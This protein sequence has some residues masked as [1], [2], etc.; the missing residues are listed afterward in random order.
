MAAGG[1]MV[2]DWFI[3][4]IQKH[5]AQLIGD[6]ELSQRSPRLHG[7]EKDVARRGYSVKT[8]LCG[9]VH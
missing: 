6:S 5:D 8:K 3:N 2:F 9:L 7:L 1:M 4:T